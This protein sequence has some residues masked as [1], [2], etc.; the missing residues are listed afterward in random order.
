M[1]YDIDVV[2]EAA[3]MAPTVAAAIIMRILTIITISIN[4]H[5]SNTTDRQA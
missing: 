5:E 3:T 4:H 2:V 1:L